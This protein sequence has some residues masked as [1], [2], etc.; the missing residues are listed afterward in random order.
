MAV[1]FVDSAVGAYE[2][3]VSTGPQQAWALP[4]PTAGGALTEGDF[5]LFAFSVDTPSGTTAAPVITP[6]SGAVALV[7]STLTSGSSTSMLGSAVYYKRVTAA[8]AAAPPAS[9]PFG[10]DAAYDGTWSVSRFRGVDA[11]SPFAISTDSVAVAAA[12]ST[13]SV[14]KTSPSVTTT[15]DAAMLVAGV[16]HRSGS[17]T[18]TSGDPAGYTRAAYGFALGGRGHAV[19]Y[20]SQAT[21]GASTTAVW[22]ESSGGVGIAWQTALRPAAT[23]P[24]ADTTAPTVPAGVTATASSATA[25]AL[26]WTA[27]TDATGVASYRVRRGGVDLATVTG[28]SYTD[29]TVA[30]STAYSY[31]V[32]A[33]DAAGNRSAESTAATVTTPAPPAAADSTAPTAPT[34]L[35]VTASSAA[36]VA[37]AWTASTDAVGVASYRVRRNGTVLSGA[38][39]ITGTSFTDDT[40][41]A[42]TAYSYT[43]S[44]V[45]A[46]GNRSAESTAATATTPVGTAAGPV[47]RDVTVGEIASGT[48]V[49]GVMPATAAAGDLLLAHV[50]GNGQ[51]APSTPPAGWTLVTSVDGITAS[52]VNGSALFYKIAAAGDAGA[53]VSFTG[54]STTASRMSVIVARVTGHNASTPFDVAA[55]AD[56]GPTGTTTFNAPAITTVNA[57]ALV[58]WFITKNSGSATAGAA[59]TTTDGPTR[60]AYTD[61][62]VEAGRV[63]AAFTQTQAAAGSTGTPLFTSAASSQ[64]TAITAAVRPAAAASTA[65][66]GTY[67]SAWTGDPDG[68]S[69]PI[70]VKT[71]GAASVRL[72]VGTDA[73]VTT[74]VTWTAPVVPDS[75]GYSR[76]VLAGL[77]NGAARRYQVEVD[78]VLAAPVGSFTTDTPAAQLSYRAAFGSCLTSGNST[79]TAFDNILANQP[80]LMLHLGD[81]GYDNNV[82]TSQASQQASVEKQIAANGGLRDLI[83]QVPTVW[84]FSDHDSGQN[85][86]TGGPGPQT[87]AVL[88]SYAEVVPYEGTLPAG[89]I[90]RA[91]H[92]GRI[93][94]ILTDG[95]SFKSAASATDDANKTMFGMAQEAWIAQQLADAA[96]LVK[97][98][99][100]DV[101]WDYPTTAGDDKWGGYKAAGQRLVDAITAAKARVFLIH[102]DAHSLCADDGTSPNNLGGLPVAGAAPFGNSTSVKGGPYSQGTWPT[103]ANVGTTEQQHGLLDV[104]DTGDTIT[105]RFSGRDKTNTERVTLTK[106]WDVATPTP[107]PTAPNKVLVGS[108]W[109]P[110][111]PRVLAGGSWLPDTH[112][113]AI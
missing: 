65:T 72:K 21:A 80:R 75:S 37:L 6:P 1:A 106:T 113:P 14:S 93:K 46:A 73:G 13:S 86:W 107:A 35:T 36:A 110:E 91:V 30:A 66:P 51:T 98:L 33:V 9:Y 59:P 102:G 55:A 52:A 89:G 100:V 90:Y 82:S 104:T 28:T 2:A 62:A 45:D 4:V 24:A 60:I 99:C 20:A 77:P 54:G 111:T 17:A 101:P 44:A 18:L 71:T 96:Y 56:K 94:Y 92:C 67:V 42:G 78:G 5:L 76:F 70:K 95:R 39:A 61:G 7:A 15:A 38:G 81:W 69:V 112:R 49:T 25:V 79:R 34:G 68:D 41:S 53:S 27:S 3:D 88:A 29:A 22:R 58:L 84:Q 12:T 16:T 74:G 23:A 40:V 103:A 19:A 48:A 26:S 63:Q 85:D 64:W 10:F 108:T 105:I 47:V 43:V 31:T 32:S 87:P 109:R 57:N 50:T 83:R 97:V 8:E 11:A